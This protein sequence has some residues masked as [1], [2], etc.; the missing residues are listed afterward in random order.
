MPVQKILNLNEN[1]FI[2]FIRQCK[3]RL[4]SAAIAAMNLGLDNAR[5]YIPS[6]FNKTMRPTV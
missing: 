5:K 2:V 3:G 4:S 6:E 1:I